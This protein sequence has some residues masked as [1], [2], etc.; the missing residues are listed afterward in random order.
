M[1]PLSPGLGWALMSFPAPSP[2]GKQLQPILGV[3]EEGKESCQSQE[4]LWCDSTCREM[5]FCL[6][7]AIHKC[8]ELE[9]ATQ[10]RGKGFYFFFFFAPFVQNWK[11]EEILS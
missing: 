7:L 2:P 11:C 5:F 9:S 3:W 1:S 4:W 10:T 6:C 8:C